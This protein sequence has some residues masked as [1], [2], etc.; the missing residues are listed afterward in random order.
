MVPPV[1]GLDTRR[2]TADMLWRTLEEP[3]QSPWLTVSEVGRSGQGRS[4]RTITFGEG[5]VDLLL[6]SQ[7]H[8][9]EA[10]ATRALADLVRFLAARDDLHSGCRQV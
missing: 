10:T 6:W 7:M 4:L 8:G 1:E 9:D 3:L 5:P 2:V